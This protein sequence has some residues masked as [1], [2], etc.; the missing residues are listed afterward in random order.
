MPSE[1]DIK[2]FV[3][4]DDEATRQS[5]D[6]VLRSVGY[7]VET[8]QSGTHFFE[9]ADFLTYGCII[10]DVRLPGLSGLEIQKRFQKIDIRMPTVFI[11]GHGD[12]SMAVQAMKYGAIDFLTKPFRDQDILDAI[13]K[14]KDIEFIRRQNDATRSDALGLLKNLSPRERQVLAFT[15]DGKR[16]KQIAFM[17][18]I[19]ESTVKVHRRNLLVKLK[20]NNMTQIAQIFGSFLDHDLD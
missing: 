16:N 13:A 10:L 11:T 14:A 5:L 2:V 8:Y 6:S 20:S 17:L 7:N 4:D 18:S 12:I 1:F 3:I 19:T 9:E 15:L